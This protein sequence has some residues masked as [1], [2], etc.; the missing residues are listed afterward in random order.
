MIN[1]DK[2][3]KDYSRTNSK[4]DKLYSIL[5]TVLDLLGPLEEKV[6]LDVG[7]GNGFFTEPIAERAKWTYGIDSSRRQI[8][9]AKPNHKIEYRI[10]SMHSRNLPKCPK[11][12]T[13][14]SA[15]TSS[16]K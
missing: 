3:A 4:P 11:S 14:A 10:Q 7:C 13:S 2:D 12:R 16:S 6:V 5:P 15:L 1:F 9:I 8:S